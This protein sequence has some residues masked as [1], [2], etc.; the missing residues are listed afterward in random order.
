MNWISNVVRPK[1]RSFL[2]RESSENLWIKCPETGQLVFYKDVEANR[3]VIPGSDYH[4]R[5][6]AVARLKAMFDGGQ[7]FLLVDVREPNEYEIVSIDGSVLIPKNEFLNGSALEQMPQDRQIVVSCKT[8]MR[9]AEV[10]AVLKG[11]GFAN[12]VHVGGGISAWVSQIEPDK[13]SY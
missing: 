6:G 2:K 8:G 9:S 3:F 1:I 12:S 10:L 7:D 13:P 5:M 11:A 4:M